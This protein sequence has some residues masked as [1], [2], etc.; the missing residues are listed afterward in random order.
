MTIT[1]AR[2][3]GFCAL[4][5]CAAWLV[6]TPTIRA[7]LP[8]SREAAPGVEPPG[9][10]SFRHW[11]EVQRTLKKIRRAVQQ[12]APAPNLSVGV[13]AP[14]R[15]PFVVVE[16]CDSPPEMVNRKAEIIRQLREQIFGSATPGAPSLRAYFNQ[17]FDGKL[18]FFDP[19]DIIEVKLTHCLADYFTSDQENSHPKRWFLDDLGDALKAQ[20]VNL[21]AYVNDGLK[22]AEGELADLSGDPE[23]DLAE[24]FVLMPA[25]N[26]DNSIRLWP[27]H[28]WA[29]WTTA[30]GWKAGNDSPSLLIAQPGSERGSV[31]LNSY[32][33]LPLQKK[34]RDTDIIG[35]GFVAHEM[36]HS[37]GLPDLYDRNPYNSTAGCGGWC[38][39]SYG[40]YG[41]LAVLPTA[42]VDL[43]FG[44]QAIWPSAWCRAFLGGGGVATPTEPEGDV[45]LYSPLYGGG[46]VSLR[47]NFPPLPNPDGRGGWCDHYLLIEFRGPAQARPGRYD[48]DRLLPD[49]G[50]LIWEV[51]EDVGRLNDHG[52][53]NKYWPCT[54]FDADG[55]SGQ[56]DQNAPLVGLCRPDAVLASNL[57]KPELLKA[58]HLWRPGSGSF[59]HPDGITISNF[60]IDGHQARLHYKM[61]TSAP[62]LTAVPP[63]L[64][65][66]AAL[67]LAAPA[68]QAAVL[69]EILSTPAQEDPSPGIAASASAVTPSP[70]SA[71]S[72]SADLL[73][74]VQSSVSPLDAANT[75]FKSFALPTSERILAQTRVTTEASQ[76][77]VIDRFGAPLKAVFKSYPKFDHELGSDATGLKAF[78]LPVNGQTKR[79]FAQEILQ[80][81]PLL[82]SITGDSRVTVMADTITAAAAKDFEKW[83]VRRGRL[84]QDLGVKIGQTLLR[85]SDTSLVL[86]REG[87]GGGNIRYSVTN[88]VQLPFLPVSLEGVV[89]QADAQAFLNRYL[90]SAVDQDA[91]WELVVQNGTGKL[92][93]L[94]RIP[95][96]PTSGP[97]TITLDAVPPNGKLDASTPV[98]IK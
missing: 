4:A 62:L 98:N 7:S 76:T 64:P 6:W 37:F 93:W 35:P 42:T 25:L 80:Q 57:S 31:A 86:Q 92:Q 78:V 20:S 19:A 2:R 49:A 72:P 75:P 56:N 53:Q 5:L 55:Y 59:V 85:I 28:S 1:L 54:Y 70:A 10:Q 61:N 77:K 91:Q 65:V 45:A 46:N 60:H 18:S 79:T 67:A 87:D 88:R 23:I 69:P 21:F 9:V 44:A 71:A 38:C 97:I 82:K 22:N 58:G 3:S 73:A 81:L 74:S 89:S 13:A 50:F 84:R 8:G 26:D 83:R 34:A 40:M 51:H 33:V 47:L 63:A 90:G 11:V 30:D 94:Y 52:G 96:V 24:I 48:W 39:L 16:L 95:T 27:K 29:K 14:V 66:V 15:I 17:L 68:A 36:L 43:P 32:C 41:G 12:A